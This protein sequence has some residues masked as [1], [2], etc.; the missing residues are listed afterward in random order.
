MKK[1]STDSDVQS[2]ASPITGH[3]SDSQGR[4]AAVRK[5]LLGSGAV[6]GAASSGWVKPVV[7]SVIVPVHA[8]TSLTR[9]THG[10]GIEDP[11]VLFYNCDNP[12]VE[13]TVNGYISA[14]IADVKVKLT[15]TWNGVGTGATDNRSPLEKNVVTAGDGTYTT[16]ENIG[17]GLGSVSVVAPIARNHPN[18]GRGA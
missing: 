9:V 2:D 11:V 12:D 16:I 14:P 5:I 10:D 13:V 15:L 17:N 18:P 6:A 1:V 4:R 8:Q 3:E 7:E